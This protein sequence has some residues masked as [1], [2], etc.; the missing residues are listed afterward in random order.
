MRIG[1]GSDACEL[2]ESHL[3]SG[4]RDRLL[5]KHELERRPGAQAG[6][7]LDPRADHAREAV[8]DGEAKTRPAVLARRRSVA[9]PE[10]FENVREIFGTNTDARVAHGELDLAG[11]LRLL[12]AELHEYR[13]RELHGVG[14]E[15]QEDATALL[16]VGAH[17]EVS[18]RLDVPEREPLVARERLHGAGELR[19]Q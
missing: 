3:P 6:L 7:D 19:R 12:G 10:V 4:M 1:A 9:L 8:A 11:A 5:R 15:V 2:M 18:P 17:G 16:A 14:E 13:L